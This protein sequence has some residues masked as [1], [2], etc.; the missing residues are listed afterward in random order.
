MNCKYRLNIISGV[1][2]QILF[3][4]LITKCPNWCFVL[5]CLYPAFVS[6]Q[7]HLAGGTGVGDCLHAVYTEGD[8][9]AR[10][11]PEHTEGPTDDPGEGAALRPRAA[12]GE[13]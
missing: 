4:F 11:D 7:S 5:N 1:H 2:R 12:N 13:S 10:P 8:E 3:E 6:A 9:A